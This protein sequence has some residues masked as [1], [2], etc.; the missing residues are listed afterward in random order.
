MADIIAGRKAIGK[1]FTSAGLEN[2]GC[3]I[4][5]ERTRSPP[6][7]GGSVLSH[8]FFI[9]RQAGKVKETG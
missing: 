2:A 3:N 8:L 9:P 7:R 6:E 4:K 1:F 5:C